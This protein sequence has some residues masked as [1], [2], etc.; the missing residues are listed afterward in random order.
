[1]ICQLQLSPEQVLFLASCGM[2]SWYNEYVSVDALEFKSQW[3]LCE[4]MTMH[5]CLYLLLHS[6]LSEAPMQATISG[7]SNLHLLDCKAIQM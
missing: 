2:S 1:M 4:Y 6:Q 7:S 3:P 5:D